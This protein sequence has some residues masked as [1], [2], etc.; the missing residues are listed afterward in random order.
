LTKKRVF[1][2]QNIIGPQEFICVLMQILCHAFLLLLPTQSDFQLERRI[3]QT[4]TLTASSAS[5]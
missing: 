4:C 2:S 5:R 3:G 1:F